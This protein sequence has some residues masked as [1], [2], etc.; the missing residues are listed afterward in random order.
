MEGVP[1]GTRADGHS[2]QAHSSKDPSTERANKL[3]SGESPQLDVDRGIA[4][5]QRPASVGEGSGD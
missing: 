2:Y 1:A 4:R 3:P 5:G